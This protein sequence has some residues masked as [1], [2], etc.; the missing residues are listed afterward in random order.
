M[1][2]TVS[3]DDTQSSLPASKARRA[4]FVVLERARLILVLAHILEPQPLRLRGAYTV[5]LPYDLGTG[6]VSVVC[7]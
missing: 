6:V 5:M 2:Y 7:T 4:S 3:R 1:R